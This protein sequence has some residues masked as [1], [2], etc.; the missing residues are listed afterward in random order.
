MS[1]NDKK[2]FL[3]KVIKGIK[4]PK[5]AIAYAFFLI[6][7]KFKF[8]EAARA[9]GRGERLIIRGDLRSAENSNDFTTLAHI[10]RYKWV[11]PY[12]KGLRCLD[13]G[14]GSG[15]GAHYLA[16]SGAESVIGVDISIQTINYAK[17]HY[18][19]QN[20]VYSQMSVCD[21][22]FKDDY[23]DAVVSFDVLE[24]LN[25]KDQEIFISEIT[26]VL[27][28]KGA[29]YIGCPNATVSMGNNPYHL[30]ELTKTEFKSLLQN[31]FM[32]IQVFGQD[33]LING[34]RQRENWF[35]YLSSLS[36][37]NLVITEEDSDFTFGLIAI[38]QS[39]KRYKSKL[40]RVENR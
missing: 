14:C 19:E 33:I 28:Y 36:D 30:K 8:T 20:L 9:S 5:K 3:A 35:K 17:K 1:K 15:Y 16:K 13:A 21:L 22:K 40:S 10:Q 2:S 18:K 37:Q 29:L 38:C 6:N 23:F 39:P 11:E 31:Y 26:R 25:N 34:I 12:I 4:N 7:N 27:N 24:H 32:D